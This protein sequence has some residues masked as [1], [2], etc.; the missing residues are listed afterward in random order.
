MSFTYV[1][2]TAG[3]G[4]RD[5]TGAIPA[6][7]VRARPLVEMTNDTKTIPKEVIIPF[8]ANGT[9]THPLAATTDPATTPTGNVYRFIVEAAGKVVRSFLA[10]V[11]HD[12]GETIDIDDL[13]ELISPPGLVAEAAVAASLVSLD[14]GVLYVVDGA[15]LWNG[16][17][18][19]VTTIAPA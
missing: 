12:V 10:E 2:L 16:P 7:R 19:T 13:D 15:L 17:A 14:S 8:A 4:Y 1:Y 6:V 5:A 3:D 18:G 11:P 9:A